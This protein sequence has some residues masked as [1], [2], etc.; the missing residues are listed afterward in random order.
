MASTHV[1]LGGSRRPLRR[2][3]VRVGD[4][5]P[6]SD[7]EVTVT[8]R[9]PA[10]PEPSG[11]AAISRDQLASEYGAASGDMARAVSTLQGYGLQVSE[12][13]P[14]TRSLR[15]HGTAEDIERA[16]HAG[17]GMYRSAAQGE[18]RGRQGQLHVPAELSGIVT[19]VFG[20]DQRRVAHR[21]S[22]A[23]PSTTAAPPL[24]PAD[25]EQHYDFPPGQAEGQTIAIAEFGGAY[26]AQ[27]LA[28]FCEQIDRPQPSVKAIAVDAPIL[29][30]PQIR[31]MAKARRN[32]TLMDSIEVNMDIQIVAALC[33]AATINVYFA[34]FD[35]KG[36]V[37]LLNQ[38]I[39]SDPT[40]AAL[41]VSWGLAED[42]P[43]WSDAA[44]TEIDQRLQA[45]TALGITPCVA[46]GDDGSGDQETDGRA[47][48]NFP[49]SSPHVLAVGGTMLDGTTDVVW[50]EAPGQRTPNGG[51][52]TGGGVSVE[53]PRPS[54]QDV[55][56]PS[57]NAGAIDGRVVPDVAALAGPPLYDLVFLSQTQPNGGTSAAAPLWAAL[58]ARVRA[59]STTPALRFVAPLLYEDGPGGQ[60]V[61]AGAGFVDVTSGDN[62]SPKPGRGYSAGPGFDAV[63]GWGVP[64][65]TGLVNRI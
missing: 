36:W 7:I 51:G 43:D 32:N 28:T 57:L 2:D 13:S 15:V 44:R 16:F 42:D 9:G 14:A 30:F 1:V 37:D 64:R 27:D 56:V 46:A 61:G 60:P 11:G 18:Y 38:V 63:S 34:T 65:G 40:P 53:F 10:L 26:F 49:A 12:Q 6:R 45:A 24:A 59:A 31:R 48:V 23:A 35:E 20:L 62:T 3:A 39:L 33:P 22:A 41:S 4:V 25:L 50:W 19:G 5:D 17:L 29:S 55:D 52:S 21:T 47:H 54:W 8:L 58:I